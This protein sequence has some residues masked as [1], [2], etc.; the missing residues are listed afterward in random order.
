MRLS[1]LQNGYHE[2]DNDD[3]QD[4]SQD[5]DSQDELDDAMAEFGDHVEDAIFSQILEM[6]ESEEEREF[7]APLILGF[8]EQASETFDQMQVAL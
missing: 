7:S 1:S 6:D 2:Q 4:S 3:E 5:D 8:F